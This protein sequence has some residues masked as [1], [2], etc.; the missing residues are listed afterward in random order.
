MCPPRSRARCSSPCVFFFS[1]GAV[2]LSTCRKETTGAYFFLNK[3]LNTNVNGNGFVGFETESENF[4]T[5]VLFQ[6]TGGHSRVCSCIRIV[7][8]KSIKTPFIFPLSYFF[9]FVTLYYSFFSFLR[10]T[11]CIGWERFFTLFV[12]SSFV[13]CS[14]FLYLSI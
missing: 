3:H 4:G 12:F 6:E 1:R 2:V 10:F 11:S 8:N 13:P 7:Y 14:M 5:I 9:P